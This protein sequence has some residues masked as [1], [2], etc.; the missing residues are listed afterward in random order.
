MGEERE[1]VG[2]ELRMS[3]M[4]SEKQAGSKNYRI[5]Q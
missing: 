2:G 3:A 1:A 4:K 5:V